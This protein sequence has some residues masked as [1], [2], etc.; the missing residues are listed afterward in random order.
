MMKH[1][2]T[3]LFSLTLPTTFGQTVYEP[4]IQILAPNVTKYEKAFDKEV[5]N[6]NKEIKKNTNTSEQE[7][8]K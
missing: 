3:I 8:A 6:Y 4:Q 2:T 5:T 1:L 7:Q